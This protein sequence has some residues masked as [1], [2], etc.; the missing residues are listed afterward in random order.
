MIR[1]PICVFARFVWSVVWCV[2]YKVCFDWTA[3]LTIVLSPCIIPSGRKMGKWF[4]F[5]SIDTN[6]RLKIYAPES[7]RLRLVKL[8]KVERVFSRFGAR[9]FYFPNQNEKILEPYLLAPWMMFF[10]FVKRWQKKLPSELLYNWILFLPLQSQKNNGQLPEWPNGA[11]CNS[12]G[13][14]LRWF[15]SITAHSSLL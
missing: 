7:L 4:W 5:C 15:E 9:I 10:R 14:R 8:E 2:S 12:A 13:L 6:H 11:D 3:K 1:V